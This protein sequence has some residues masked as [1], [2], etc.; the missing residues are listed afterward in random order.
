[1]VNIISLKKSSVLDSKALYRAEHVIANYNYI[2]EH[3]KLFP[4]IEVSFDDLSGIYTFVYV[5]KQNRRTFKHL[6]LN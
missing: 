1:M 6:V 4:N 5:D 3:K 2:R